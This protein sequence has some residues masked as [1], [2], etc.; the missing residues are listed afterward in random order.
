MMLILKY[1]HVQDHL[2]RV[3]WKNVFSA[4]QMIWKVI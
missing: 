2:M 4:F 3:L 1:S